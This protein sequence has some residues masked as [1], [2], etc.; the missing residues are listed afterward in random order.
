VRRVLTGP[1]A[2][3]QALSTA[4]AG[5]WNRFFFTPA[6]PTPL[7]LIRVMVGLL[8]FWSLFVTGLDLHDFLGSHAWADP[9][10][11]RAAL[12]I[13]REIDPSWAWSFWSWV[14]DGGLRVVWA[15]CLVVLGLFTLGLGSRVTAVLAWVIAVS[16]TRRA[17]VMLF[18]F[19]QIAPTWSLYLAVCG[20]SGQAVSL[21]R[22]LARWR[23][24][25]REFA[26]RRQD[27][28]RTLSAGAPAATI[29]ANLGVRLIQLHLVLIYGMAGLAKLRGDAWW[30]G[31]AAWGVVASGEFRRLNL[32]WL[33]AYPLI[34]NALTHGGVFLE[35][36]YPVLVWNRL[37]RPLLIGAMVLLHLGIDLT[38]GLTEFGLAMLAG[39]VAFAS[40]AWL[41]SLITGWN[42]PAGR[43]LYD[44][45]CPRCRASMAI[46]TAAD[47]DRVV[48]PIDLTASDVQSVHPALTRET[49][50]RAM[51]LVRADGRVFVGFDAFVV[52]ARW[53][54]LGWPLGLLGSIPGIAPVGR[55]AYN[56]IA[57]GRP[58]DE[59][60]T[61][62]VCGIHARPAKVS[63]HE[64]NKPEAQPGR[65]T[66]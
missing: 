27:D 13:D 37:L 40:G 62:L 44:G 1:L 66:R 17:P 36:A 46:I 45:A 39:N 51:H 8:L 47:P 56:R 7:G 20:A 16:T 23:R 50:L 2:Y 38:L 22:F 53:L 63:G 49:C 31:F 15:G 18:G 42:Q 55:W 4:L 57:A 54:P 3:G 59:P 60:C 48:E 19:D 21:D 41:R 29:S 35:L 11:V 52:L 32:T 43:V 6:D 25:R 65:A 14:P 30:D 64:T 9:A 33:A 5:G 34:L 26:R 24:T 12:G 61:D 28:D 58:R 10:A